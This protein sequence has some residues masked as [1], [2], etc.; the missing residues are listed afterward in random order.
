MHAHIESAA[1]TKSSQIV[2]Q[3]LLTAA[4]VLL[5]LWAATQ[6]AAAS[7]KFHPALG[8]PWISLLGCPLYAPW[9]LFPW[10]LTFGRAAPR[11][12]DTAGLIAMAG[13]ISGGLVAIGGAAWRASKP[14]VVTTY[15]SARWA[16]V[17]DIR[18]AGLLGDRGVMLG[19]SGNSYLRDDGPHHVLAVAPTRSGKGVG[20]VVPT[21]LSWTGSA[22]IHDIKGENWELT[23]GWRQRFSN[24]LKFDPTDPSSARF[25]PLL[26]V[27]KGPNEV[28]D[29]QNIADILIDPEGAREIR[30]H[31]QKTAYGLLVGAILH[32]L[33]AEGEKT[34]AR[35]ARLLS[36]PSRSIDRTL[37]VMM[38]TNHLGTDDAPEVHPTVAEHVR[39]VMNKVPNE[40]SGVVSTAV[41]LLSLYSDPIIAKTTCRSDWRIADLMDAE[42]PHSLYLVVPP[43][44][45]SR[46]RPLMRLVLNLIG[47]R[48]TEQLETRRGHAHRRQLLL[49]LD[50]FPALGRLDFFEASLAFLAGYGVRAY[51]IAQSLNQIEKAYGAN[52]AIVDNCHVRIA[53]AA[54]DERT[55]KRLSEALGTKT[56][57]RAQR[58]LAGKRLSPWLANTSIS[59]QE[60]ARPLLTPGEVMQ[61][62]SD[63]ALVFVSGCPPIR[64][65]KLRYFEDRNFAARCLP[66]PRAHSQIDGQRRAS[67][68]WGTQAR[69]T[70]ERLVKQWGEYV[71]ETNSQET[72]PI[73]ERTPE[74]VRLPGRDPDTDLII[75]EPRQ[76]R[77]RRNAPTA[78]LSLPLPG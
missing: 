13:G 59:E 64:A 4:F 33:Y 72:G 24:C 6:W 23:S 55:A 73:R 52:N 20:L 28:R 68:A 37:W 62:P 30:D 77:G 11:V 61:L 38:T 32:V 53:F 35:V 44:D 60:T 78:Q 18:G 2:I 15:G 71:T 47:R 21:L 49:M 48:L 17:S 26:E 42:R 29:V 54:N 56:E 69:G 41:S 7:L 9:Q 22:V 75:D 16:D 50:E 3:G 57:L 51:L 65:K 39:A 76:R 25:N 27:R 43:S 58:N 10:W 36:D 67:D 46:T 5:S 8:A 12:F 66:A 19:Q 31:W 40:R 70:D 45:L 63:E 74:A 1:M 14:K 34:L